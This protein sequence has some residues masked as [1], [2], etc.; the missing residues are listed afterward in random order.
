[1]IPDEFGTELPETRVEEEQL[2]NEKNMARF[3]KSK[4]FKALKEYMEARIDFFQQ[5]LPD[6][7]SINGGLDATGKQVEHLDD[8]TIASYWRAANLVIG[9]FRRV[10]DEYE[11]ASEVVKNATKNN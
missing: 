2:V 3:S 9:E 7:N 5:Y 4:E 10:L 8:A 11:R 1:M 6:G